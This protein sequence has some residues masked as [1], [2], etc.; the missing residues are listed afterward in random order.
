MFDFPAILTCQH[1]FNVGKSYIQYFIK[2]SKDIEVIEVKLSLLVRRVEEKKQYK[3]K[4][5]EIARRHRRGPSETTALTLC[6]KKMTA[7][8]YSDISFIIR[9]QHS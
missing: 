2:I 6:K 7:S 3:E 4:K 5:G 9:T 8:S 1:F